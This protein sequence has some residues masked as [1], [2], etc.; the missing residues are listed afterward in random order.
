MFYISLLA[1]TNKKS[2]HYTE[3]QDFLILVLSRSHIDG[4]W[5]LNAAIY[6]RGIFL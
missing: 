2:N 5:D 6:Y 4:S 3:A 1:R